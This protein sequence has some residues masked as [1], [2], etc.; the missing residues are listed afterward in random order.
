MGCCCSTD[1][2]KY[3]G[4]SPRTRIRPRAVPPK[5]LLCNFHDIG[6]TGS[7]TSADS[8]PTPTPRCSRKRSKSGAARTKVTSVCVKAHRG[9]SPSLRTSAILGNSPRKTPTV[10]DAMSW[11]VNSSSKSIAFQNE[12]RGDEAPSSTASSTLS[13]FHPLLPQLPEFSPLLNEGDLALHH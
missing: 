5:L 7:E 13:S 6:T 4:A 8:E 10:V 2:A 1:N 11:S 3:A 12:R 9:A